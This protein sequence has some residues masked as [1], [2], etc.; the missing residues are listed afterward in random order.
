VEND[1]FSLED[2]G[3]RASPERATEEEYRSGN[4]LR[5]MRVED[6]SFLSLLLYLYLFPSFF[7]ARY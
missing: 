7:T 1:E 4:G 2:F 5:L 3:C 6:L